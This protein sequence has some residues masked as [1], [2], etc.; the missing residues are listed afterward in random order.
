MEYKKVFID[1]E[2][3]KEF[4]NNNSKFNI[5]CELYQDRIINKR[6]FKL[7]SCKENISNE[8]YYI[9]NPKCKYVN[10]EILFKLPKEL[11]CSY[12]DIILNK[13]I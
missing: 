8:T 6:W 9:I 13:I 5:I 4:L 12:Q 11:C 3:L 2:I 10:N 7:I 1:S